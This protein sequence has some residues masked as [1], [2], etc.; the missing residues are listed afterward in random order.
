MTVN[1][2][3]E[4]L[5]VNELITKYNLMVP[6]IQREYVWGNNE[7]DILDVFD[8]PVGIHR[9]TGSWMF[10]CDPLEIKK[11]ILVTGGAGFIGCAL[12]QKLAETG[13]RLLVVDNLY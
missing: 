11:N 10:D 7:F 6:E 2:T 9:L 13:Q 3:M 1:N 8:G 4:E 5:S 12:S